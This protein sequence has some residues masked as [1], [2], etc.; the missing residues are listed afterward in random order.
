MCVCVCELLS[1]IVNAE[2]YQHE[3]GKNLSLR[4]NNCRKKRF[5]V[6]K[7]FNSHYAFSGNIQFRQQHWAIHHEC[8]YFGYHFEKLIMFHNI[9]QY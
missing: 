2:V 1:Q 3:T 8:V 5:R 9:M 6:F 4:R 7:K